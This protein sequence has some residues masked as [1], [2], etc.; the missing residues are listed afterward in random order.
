MRGNPVLT[1]GLILLL[2]AGS[3]VPSAAQRETIRLGLDAGGWEHLDHE[4]RS[5]VMLVSGY[6]GSQD[7]VIVPDSYGEGFHTDLLLSFDDGSVRPRGSSYAVRQSSGQLTE[8]VVARGTGALAL[9]AGGDG[10]VLQ[11]RPGALFGPNAVWQD[12]TIEFWLYP[13]A[14]T[15]G[16]IVLSW[17]GSR[18]VA[19]GT[20]PQSVYVDVVGQRLRWSFN[21]LFGLPSTEADFTYRNIELT[22]IRRLIPHT[23]Q[24]HLFRYDATSGL[25]EYL[26]DG[27][28]EAVR[29]ATP[30][31]REEPE[32]YTAVVGAGGRGLLRVAPNLRGVIDDVRIS[33]AFI[34]RDP[35]DQPPGRRYSGIRGTAELRNIALGDRGGR[36]VEIDVGRRG[37]PNAEVWTYYRLHDLSGSPGGEWIPF[38]SGEPFPRDARGRFLD[39]RF[40]LYPDTLA[41]ES[42]RITDVA[43]VFEPDEPPAPPQRL[44]AESVSGGVRL[45][46]SPTYEGDVAGY[47]L[48]YGTTPGSY[49]GRGGR[50][51]DSGRVDSPIDVGL[52]REVTLSGLETGR[53]YF[54]AVAAYDELGR[55]RPGVLSSEVSARPMAPAR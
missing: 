43:V 6:R 25:M 39:I 16:E 4:S 23:W 53:L 13:A 1:T 34:S 33:R 52:T 49:F 19:G 26:V 12:T 17:E 36:L 35:V 46:W 51:D 11:A 7:I 5:N 21:G 18:V 40:E 15:D 29:Y 24:H 44:F 41:D 37:S 48:F 54:F 22:G 55:T 47:L 20:E 8:T 32:V 2:F 9:D 31:G 38:D 45:S 3:A 14:A 42:P 27:V 30:S 10:V 28:P 50:W